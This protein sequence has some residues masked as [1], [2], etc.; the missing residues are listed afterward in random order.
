VSRRGDDQGWERRTR[1]PPKTVVEIEDRTAVQVGPAEVFQRLTDVEFVAGCLPGLVPGSL[2]PADGGQFVTRVRQTVVGVTATWQ[3]TVRIDPDES[4]RHV[5]ITLAGNE[6]RLRM[7]LEGLAQVTVEVDANDDSVLAYSGHVEVVGKL[8]AAGGPIIRRNVAEILERFVA[9]LGGTHA[10]QEHTAASE[11]ITAGVP[12]V[13][14]SF[15]FHRP[16]G[17]VCA[18]GWCAQ[19]DGACQSP[20]SGARLRDPM[21]PLGRLAERYPPW[22]YERRFLRPRLVRRRALHTLRYVSSAPGL[23]KGGPGGPT[24]MPREFREITVETVVVGDAPVPADAVHVDA[25][26]GSIALGLYGERVLGV[27]TG[28][29]LMAVQ[30]ERIVLATGGYER[31]P[32]IPGNDVPGVIGTRAAEIYGAAGALNGKRVVIWAPDAAIGP[33]RARAERNGATVVHASPASPS[34]IIGTSA[35][36]AVDVGDRIPCDLFVVG[37]RQPAIELALQA[38]CQSRLTQD[39]LPLLVATETPSWMELSGVAASTGSGVPDVPLGN[40]S[41]ACLCEDVR[42]GDLR[43]C[44]DQGFDHAELIK[45][46]T[47]AM[48]GPCQGKLCTSAVLAALRSFGVAPTPTTARPLALP[49]TLGE[50]AAHA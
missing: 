29:A 25:G 43:A 22:F 34:R 47:G 33:I 19:C 45:R 27:L 46:R 1:S 2:E 11:R 50:L 38:G 32:P 5:A 42:V 24:R 26:A 23:G 21:R 49:V 31:L 3:L 10:E 6:P 30:F 41:F 13:A 37:V 40:D 28:D 20:A 9:G 12:A 39:E 36:K 18:T 48:T 14:S 17:P 35:V 8:A 16:R 7:T 4:A 15:R 44:V